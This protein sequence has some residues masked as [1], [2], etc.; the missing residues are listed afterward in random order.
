MM[1]VQVGYQN[2]SKTE[3]FEVDNYIHERLVEH[4]YKST[5]SGVIAGFFASSII[6][7]FLY[8]STLFV[9]LIVST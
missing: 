5:P 4:L 7:I 6:F 2:L 8:Q 9:P 3:R 1:D